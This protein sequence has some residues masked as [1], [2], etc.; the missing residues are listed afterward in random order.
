MRYFAAT[1]LFLFGLA[2]CSGPGS[3]S[4]RKAL[5]YEMPGTPSATYVMESSQD[6]SV[7][8]PGMGPMDIQGSSEATLAMV[9]TQVEGGLEITA[10]F[11]K[12]TASMNNPMAAP[13]TATE[14]DVT[15]DLVFTIDAFGA[16]TVVSTPEVNEA[17]EQM[18]GAAGLAHEFFPRLPGGVVD[19]GESWTDTI[20]YEIQV[21]T[22][23]AASKSVV[24]YTLVGDTVVDGVSL[25]HITYVSDGEVVANASQAGTEVIQEFSGT[26]DGIFLWDPARNLLV[27][28]ET[29]SEMD[30]STEVPASGM[31]PFPM[32]VSAKGSVRLQGG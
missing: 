27:V 1:A 16:G 32:V 22:G 5:V 20:R 9:F 26:T 19:P 13:I 11:E 3:V 8:I 31:P 4:P 6:I 18:V 23:E 7:D 30:G 29:D 24:T 25:L 15:G 10:T 14:S 17:V 2:A 12:L 28:N 21:G